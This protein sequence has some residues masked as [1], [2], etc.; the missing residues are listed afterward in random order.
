MFLLLLFQP[1]P[2]YLPDKVYLVAT[3]GGA[4]KLDTLLLVFKCLKEPYFIHSG[5]VV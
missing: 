5:V 1:T 3:P 2:F 4:C